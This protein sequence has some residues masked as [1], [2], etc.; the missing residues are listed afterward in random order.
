M[1]TNENDRFELDEMAEQEPMHMCQDCGER[2]GVNP[3]KGPGD[4][5]AVLICEECTPRG[6]R[7]EM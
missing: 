6:H 7:F 1:R 3:W 4:F 2:P 5:D